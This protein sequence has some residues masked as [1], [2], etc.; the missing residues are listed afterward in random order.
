MNNLILGYVRI[1]CYAVL[2]CMIILIAANLT[3]ENFKEA[4]SYCDS[5]MKVSRALDTEVDA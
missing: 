3:G 5:L 1:T 4:K 2:Y